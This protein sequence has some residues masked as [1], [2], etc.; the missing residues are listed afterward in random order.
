MDQIANQLPSGNDQ[1]DFSSIEAL[2]IYGPSWTNWVPFDHHARSVLLPFL[3]A[4][5]WHIRQSV[6]LSRIEAIT[7]WR[8]EVLQ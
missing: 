6:G 4:T 8:P 1:E 2:V 7:P 3:R 5:G